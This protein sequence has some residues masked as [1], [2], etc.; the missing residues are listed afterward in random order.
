MA[1]NTK[2]KEEGGDRAGDGACGRRRN[3]KNAKDD[4]GKKT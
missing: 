4:S 2:R 3:V 1:S